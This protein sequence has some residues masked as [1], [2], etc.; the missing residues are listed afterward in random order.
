MKTKKIKFTDPVIKGLKATGKPYSH[1]DT[2]HKGL[3]IRVSATGTKTFALAYHSKANQRTRMKREDDKY[4]STEPFIVPLSGIAVDLIK[5]AR[6]GRDGRVFGAGKVNSQAHM[7]R[8]DPAALMRAIWAKH[9][10]K[11]AYPHDLRRTAGTL[12]QSAVLPDRPK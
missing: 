6:G 8:D 5:R 3:M 7:R 1:G 10:F 2:E 11:H 12:V 4:D 9:K